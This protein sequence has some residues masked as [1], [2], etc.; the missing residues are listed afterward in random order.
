MHLCFRNA[1]SLLQDARL[2]RPTRPERAISL[3]VLALEET[4]KIFM[5]CS[6][7]GEIAGQA[8]SW[9]KVKRK[10]TS[11]RRKQRLFGVYGSAVLSEFAKSSGKKLYEQPVPPGLSPLLNR[12]KQLGFY[13][14]W[15]DG[16]FYSP[17]QMGE[18]NAQWADWL[19]PAVEER[20]SSIESM[21]AT[22]ETSVWVAAKAAGL[23]GKLRQASTVDEVK[24]VLRKFVDKP[25]SGAAST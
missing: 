20:L 17:A 15:I 19:I 3:A 11:H 14:D 9:R 23:S 25:P 12:M 5:L 6:L 1:A 7:A 18:Q 13:V 21:H 22:E 16:A 8:T 2:L 24:Q 10:L 4:G